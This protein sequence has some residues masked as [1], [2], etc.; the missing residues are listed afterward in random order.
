MYA[1]IERERTEALRRRGFL[2]EK[3]IACGGPKAGARAFEAL[4]E[5]IAL[6]IVKK[7]KNDGVAKRTI[8]KSKR[9][10]PPLTAGLSRPIAPV[11]T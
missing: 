1:S 8:S 4:A 2:N 11:T 6:K 7:K 9:G 5:A 3:G 10:G